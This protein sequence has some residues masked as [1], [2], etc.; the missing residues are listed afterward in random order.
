MNDTVNDT[1]NNTNIDADLYAMLF[2]LIDRAGLVF[3]SYDDKNAYLVG[4]HAQ[5]LQRITLESLLMLTDSQKRE[6]NDFL[7][8]Q[9]SE[10]A[11]QKFFTSRIDN[12]RQRILQKIKD[13]C[14]ET[15]DVILLS[16]TL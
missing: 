5:L 13:F 4:L 7:I 8:L 11:V 1:A 16:K 3:D 6:Y 2:D 14:Q 10:I 12:Y 15:Y 9:P